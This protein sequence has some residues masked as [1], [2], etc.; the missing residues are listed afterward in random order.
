MLTRLTVRIDRK[1]ERGSVLP[2]V[3]LTIVTLIVFTAFVVDLGPGYNERRLDQTAADAA[4]LA[5]AAALP[6]GLNA[7]ATAAMNEA[8]SNI[9]AL[10]PADWLAC[11]DTPPAEYTLF[12]TASPGGCIAV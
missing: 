8:Q 12:P 10:T 11:T 1:S 7:V 9:P 5:G 2:L 6:G 3:A 4:A